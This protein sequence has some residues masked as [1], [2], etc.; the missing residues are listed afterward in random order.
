[1]TGK[2]VKNDD[3]SSLK[4][5]TGCKVTLFQ[6]G[7]FGGWHAT[8]PAGEYNHAA[9]LRKGAKNDDMSSLKIV[10]NL[11]PANDPSTC[12][13]PQVFKESTC[14]CGCENGAELALECEGGARDQVV[15][16]TEWD[17]ATCSC[18][19]DASSL[20]EFQVQ[21]ASP[22]CAVT[23]KPDI[24]AKC[25]T[26]SKL[27]SADC[28]KCQCAADSPVCEAPMVRGDNCACVCPV[29]PTTGRSAAD[30]CTDRHAVLDP[31][32][33]GCTCPNPCEGAK[34]HPNNGDCNTCQCPQ[35]NDCSSTPPIQ[36]ILSDTTCLFECGKFSF[37]LCELLHW[38]YLVLT[39]Y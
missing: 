25:E 13:A 9:M 26:E 21:S 17:H 3:V 19:C 37:L 18:K 20:T 12:T 22:Q 38:V 1:M 29:E 14:S 7:Q 16:L 30:V 27:P 36:S 31:Q 32:T 24:V 28:S 6:H 10:S 15:P 35:N 5:P 11:K 23:C 2:G 33:C 8:F 39:L 34:V 4:V